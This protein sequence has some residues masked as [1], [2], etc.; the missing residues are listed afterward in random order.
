M[1]NTWQSKCYYYH[2]HTH[3]TSCWSS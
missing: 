3:C 1:T 2:S